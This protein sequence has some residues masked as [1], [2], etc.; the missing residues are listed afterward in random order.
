MGGREYEIVRAG[1]DVR[2]TPQDRAAVLGG[3]VMILP[4]VEP[5]SGPFPG[6]PMRWTGTPA[7]EGERIA[8]LPFYLAQMTDTCLSLI[9]A[10]GPV[11]VEGP[12]A[13]NPDFLDMLASLRPAGIEV[14]T[15]ATGTSAGAALLCLTEVAAPGDPAGPATR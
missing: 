13:R 11:V 12:F 14:A 6:R 10:A 1:S 3:M 15:S 4:A 8:A 7:T 5:M 2:P 9:G